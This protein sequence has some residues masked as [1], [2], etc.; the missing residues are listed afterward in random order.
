[1]FMGC[2]GIPVSANMVCSGSKGGDGS[3]VYVTPKA[4]V[5]L[6]W[7]TVELERFPLGGV[8]PGVVI[9]PFVALFWRFLA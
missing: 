5:E 6:G 1:M 3:N 9:I 2:C 4:R 7:V 8:W